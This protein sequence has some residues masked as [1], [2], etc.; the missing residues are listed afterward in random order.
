MKYITAATFALLLCA[1][2]L[3]QIKRDKEP[4]PGILE[5]QR[6]ADEAYDND[7]YA[8]SEKYYLQLTEKVPKEARNWFRLGNV[9]ARTERPNLAIKAYQEALL[10][11]PKQSKA[12]YNMGL[13]Y[14]R[15]S[16]NSFINLQTYVPEQDPL[17]QR[18]KQIYEEITGILDGK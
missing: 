7:D 5:V 4:Q 13:L 15:Q 6:L 10:R 16:A 2:N 1:C 12:W 17:S 9:F 18:G 11:D 14:L 8:N 3:Q